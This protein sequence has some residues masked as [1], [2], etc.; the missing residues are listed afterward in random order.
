MLI[1][2]KQVSV[3]D[4]VGDDLRTNFRVVR[5]NGLLLSN[6]QIAILERNHISYHKCKNME[7]L[8][9]QIETCLD[10]MDDIDSELEEVSV[11]ID[12]YRYYHDIQH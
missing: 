6:Y 5:E 8:S 4:L 11:Q 1:N 9:F 12:E 2:G 10:S 7:E 3:E